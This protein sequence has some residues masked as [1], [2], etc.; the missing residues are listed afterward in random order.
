MW[1]LMMMGAQPF[2]DFQVDDVSSG[3]S[4]GTQPTI[5]TAASTS[6]APPSG[7]TLALKPTLPSWLFDDAGDLSFTFLGAVNVTYHNP[8]FINTYDDG[9][10]VTHVSITDVGGTKKQFYSTGGVI[11]SPYAEDVRGG[12]YP[13]IEMHFSSETNGVVHNAVAAP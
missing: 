6:E 12:K 10:V 7:L 4:F 1:N 2:V 11:P 5:A 8:D 9:V 3:G 13:F